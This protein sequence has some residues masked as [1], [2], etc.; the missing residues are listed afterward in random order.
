MLVDFY[1]GAL[2]VG[3]SSGP[4]K[5]VVYWAAV[6]EEIFAV[7]APAYEPIVDFDPAQAVEV[8]FITDLDLAGVDREGLVTLVGNILTGGYLDKPGVKGKGEAVLYILV[9]EALQ[10]LVPEPED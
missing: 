3:G 2:E 10:A 9:N 4:Q 7:S 5:H 8:D 1:K 6:S